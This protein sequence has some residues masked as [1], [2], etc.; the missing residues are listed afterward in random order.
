MHTSAAA[1]RSRL[2]G[3]RP[4]EPTGGVSANGGGRCG[5]DGGPSYGGPSGTPAAPTRKRWAAFISHYKVEA[6][7]EARF[8]QTEL[9]VRAQN[10]EY[11]CRI[12]NTE[13]RI[14]NAEYR[15]QNTEHRTVLTHLQ[16]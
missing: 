2:F 15:M 7:M 16:L 5:W 6:A 9:E 10:T 14:Q 4:E 13:N 8:L 3:P 12:Q 11:R 1:V